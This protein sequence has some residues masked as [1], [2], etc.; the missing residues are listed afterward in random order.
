MCI[1][2]THGGPIGIPPRAAQPERRAT[3]T[4]IGKGKQ[5]LRDIP[6]SVTVVT[7]S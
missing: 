4:T 3:T 5:E 6:Q 7:E 2:L 1:A